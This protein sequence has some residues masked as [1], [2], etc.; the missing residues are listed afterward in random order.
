MEERPP[1]I[2]VLPGQQELFAVPETDPRDGMGYRGPVAAMAAGISYRQLDHW[3]RSGLVSPSIRRASGTGSV[4]LYSFRDI[5]ALQVVRR[6]LGTGLS[7]GQV[8]AA[9]ATVRQ[10]GEA[11]LAGMTL[12]S[13]G[14]GVFECAHHDDVVDLV[15]GGQGV[16][17]LGLGAAWQDVAG[18][19][20]E[21]PDDHCEEPAAP[22]VARRHLR[23]VS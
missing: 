11:D 17:V 20:A 10:R 14:T 22:G 4:R 16:L 5:L 13:D 3:D 8:R 18:F 2:A 7:L 21:L 6:L 19:L 12:V 9:V 15:R 23:P 1:P